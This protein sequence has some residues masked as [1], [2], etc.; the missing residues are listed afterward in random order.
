MG[1]T[2]LPPL[3]M[4]RFRKCQTL[5]LVYH[6]EKMS[7]FAALAFLDLRLFPNHLFRLPQNS[8]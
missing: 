8:L 6:K 3:A 2:P 4:P 7:L 1:Q 5:Q